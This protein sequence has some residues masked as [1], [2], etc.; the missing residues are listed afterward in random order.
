MTQ[1]HG[2]SITVDGKVGDFSE[3]VVTLPRELTTTERAKA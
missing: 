2:G 3:F 1:Q